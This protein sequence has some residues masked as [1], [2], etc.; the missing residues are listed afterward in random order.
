MLCTEE[1]EEAA[2][3][4][5]LEEEEPAADVCSS[6]VVEEDDAAAETVE[7]ELW[8]SVDEVSAEVDDDA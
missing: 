2:V 3:S 6:G 1:V 8:L 5:E 4:P 7:L